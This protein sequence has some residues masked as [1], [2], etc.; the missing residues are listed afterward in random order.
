MTETLPLTPAISAPSVTDHHGDAIRVLRA[1]QA[2]SVDSVACDPPYAITPIADVTDPYRV[3]PDEDDCECSVVPSDLCRDAARSAGSRACGTCFLE[4][5]VAAFASARMLKQQSQN[6]HESA[7]HSRGFADN[8][9]R[10][11]GRWCCLWARECLRVLKPGGQLVAFAGT[12]SWHRLASGIEDAG[13]ELRDS[14]AW[15]YATGFPKSVD[16]PPAITRHIAG[17]GAIDGLTDGDKP[18]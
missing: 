5:E 3:H 2:D 18:V 10:Q 6:W 11:F 8:D 1:P 14:L 13:F 16:M 7:T 17:H 4:L 9:P 12:R 15:L